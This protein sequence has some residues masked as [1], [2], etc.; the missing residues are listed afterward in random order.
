MNASNKYKWELIPYFNHKNVEWSSLSAKHLYGKFLNYTDEEDFVGADLAK[1]MLER[2][3]NKSVKFKGY[4]NQACA[5]E[6]F[7]SLED[8]FYDNSCEKTIKN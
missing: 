1:K 6:N 8:C 3:K 4:Y 2:G 7:L 5:N